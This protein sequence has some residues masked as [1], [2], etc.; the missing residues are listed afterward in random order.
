[1]GRILV[2][3]GTAWLGREVAREAVC[4]G[5][6]VTCLAR[7]E[8]GSVP[9]D[10]RWVR[11]DRSCP[12]AYDEVSGT[13]WDEVVD[14]S[15][16][17]GLV[18]SAVAAL[19]ERAGHWTYVSSCSVYADHS[20]PGV[21]ESA[22]LLPAL[23]TDEADRESYGEAKVA[24]EQ[25]VVASLGDRAL[26]AR[27]GLIGG[28]GDASD[29]YGYW[30]GR[31]A[32]AGAEPVLVPDSPEQPTQTID[33]RDLAAWLVLAGERG[34]SG[35]VN[36]VGEQQPLGYLLATA[37]E[38]AGHIGG[39]DAAESSW[40]LEHDVNEWAGPRSL[41]L[42]I[43]APTH[44]GFGARSDVR[45]L[46]LGLARRPAEQTLVDTLAFER[47]LGL[48]RERQAGLSRADE[49]E[50]IEALRSG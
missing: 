36:A 45:A 5:H 29:R 25:A 8:S 40:L 7:G 26:L 44:A 6:E 49:L 13:S 17:P 48:D 37:A 14:V 9:D 3:G 46:A 19:A 27:A 30:V 20:R 11:V 35:P 24:C 38:V 12:G 22:A 10:V 18:R 41:P 21:D 1:M 23:D 28:P 43:A 47:E 33:V 2:L 15:W 42:W 39:L 16:Q 4:R 34:A 32:L 50:L 31:F